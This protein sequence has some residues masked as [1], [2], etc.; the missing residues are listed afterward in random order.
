VI[1]VVLGVLVIQLMRRCSEFPPLAALGSQLQ[2]TF[3]TVASDL[4]SAGK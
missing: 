4:Q 2:S 3:S 1:S